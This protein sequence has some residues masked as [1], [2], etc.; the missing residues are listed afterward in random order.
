MNYVPFPEYIWYFPMSVPLLMP[1]LQLG[2]ASSTFPHFE[3]LLLI[4]QV[5][6]EKSH[7]L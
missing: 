1:L 6:D 7:L 5:T 3:I 4:L 2:V